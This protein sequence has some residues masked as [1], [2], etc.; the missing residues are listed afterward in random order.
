[1]ISL[2]DDYLKSWVCASC[3]CHFNSLFLLKDV[4]F[5]IHTPL[6]L[7][8]NSIIVFFFFAQDKI[9]PGQPK[10]RLFTVGCLDVATTGLIIVTNDGIYNAESDITESSSY[11]Y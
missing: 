11:S 4:L 2:F 1:M 10:P 6:C 7:V 8:I 3:T 9:N 5:L